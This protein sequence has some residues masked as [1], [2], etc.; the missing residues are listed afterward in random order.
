M[1][2]SEYPKRTPKTLVGKGQMMSPKLQ[3]L[4]GVFF[5]TMFSFMSSSEAWKTQ[6]PFDPFSHMDEPGSKAKRPRN[7]R[8]LVWKPLSCWQQP[9]AFG[10]LEPQGISML[11]AF[12]DFSW[13]VWHYLSIREAF[14]APCKHR[15]R[16]W[17]HCAVFRPTKVDRDRFAAL[18][19]TS[20]RW[21]VFLK[22]PKHD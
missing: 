10:R 8:S 6:L 4:L 16:T 18:A 19:H 22:A 20:T 11:L 13:I 14:V 5:L 2:N 15:L 21:V 17:T 7:S 9:A 3:F 1:K 12:V